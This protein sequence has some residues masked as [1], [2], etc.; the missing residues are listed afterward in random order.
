MEDLEGTHGKHIRQRLDFP[1]DEILL[2]LA[3]VVGLVTPDQVGGVHQHMVF[4]RGK[5]AKTIAFNA[6]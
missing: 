3:E 1:K 2:F 6:F 4:Y 5:G